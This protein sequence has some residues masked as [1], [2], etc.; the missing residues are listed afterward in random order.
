MSLPVV[1]RPNASQDVRE[2][3]DH[4]EALRAGFGR[5]ILNRLDEVLTRISALPTLYAMVW[6]NVRA[7]RMRQFTYVVD[8]RV[9]DDRVEVLAVLHGSRGAS[10][11]QGRA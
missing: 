2:A 5:R 3:R 1:L 10:A 7:A 4:Y 11:W 9:H 8:F 6:R